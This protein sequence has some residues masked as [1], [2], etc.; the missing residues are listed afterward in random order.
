MSF[1]LALSDVYDITSLIPIKKI[2]LFQKWLLRLSFPLYVPNILFK[3]FSRRIIKNPLHDGKRN[4]TGIKKA[5]TCSDILI[6]DVKQ[7]SKRMNCTINDLVTA[8][9]SASIK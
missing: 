4:L 2:S 9:L 6:Q 3:A 5:A 7:T 1:L 8:S